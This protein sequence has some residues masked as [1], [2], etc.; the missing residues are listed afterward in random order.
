MMLSSV[1]L[2]PYRTF[3]DDGTYD[4]TFTFQIAEEVKE[5]YSLG[6]H[7][8]GDSGPLETGQTGSNLMLI[9]NTDSGPFFIEPVKS[10]GDSDIYDS[11]ALSSICSDDWNCSLTV[12][13]PNDNGAKFYTAGNAPFALRYADGSQYNATAENLTEDASFEIYEP[14]DARIEYSGKAWVVWACDENSG[15][16]RDLLTIP[17]N[18]DGVNENTRDFTYFSASEVVDDRT[19]ETFSN[20]DD[21]ATRGFV[22][23]ETM[24]E[25]IEAYKTA[26]SLTEVDWGEVDTV[27][28]IS[29]VDIMTYENEAREN[30][31]CEYT[32]NPGEF[33]TCVNNYM[34]DQGIIYPSGVKIQ[35]I[36]EPSNNGSY[37]SYGDHNFNV[38]IYADNYAAVTAVEL[39]D[40]EFVPYGFSVD[41]VDLVGSTL[42]NPGVLQMPLL[43]DVISIDSTGLNNF[44]ISEITLADE[45]IPEEAVS[46]TKDQT[47]GFFT[48]NFGS[49]FYDNVILK[50]KDTDGNIYYLKIYRGTL[51]EM[52]F[53]RATDFNNH[54]N[55]IRAE[56]IFDE[57]TSHE[58]Y[59]IT[60]RIIYRDGSTKLVELENLGW[61]DK[62]YG[63]EIDFSEEYS[64]EMSGKGL[65]RA[66]Y[67]YAID[68]D[69]YE[70]DIERVYFNIRYSGTTA[71]NY[72]GTFAGSG[73]GIVLEHEQH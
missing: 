33:E 71:E 42:D 55:G 22:Y 49:N 65:K 43:D 50:I 13:M 36:G 21:E 17:A 72:A 6:A 4:V 40:L 32:G 60:A 2:L 19:G 37:V 10:S 18:E 31:G 47:G 3:A 5:R 7:N 11:E 54:F 38:I 51:S 46:I 16:C 64:G 53:D 30:A 25:W 48:V 41:P 59:E 69:R 63:G 28:F 26:N 14:E 66:N 67:G 23:E 73:R 52:V 8:P 1:C 57:A 29:G 39:D 45:T 70:D 20:F 44:T 61:V 56:L 34:E 27:T 24:E 68:D 35:S 15:V 58:D 62:N 9:T 12:T